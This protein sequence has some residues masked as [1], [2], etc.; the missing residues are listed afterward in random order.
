[1]PT[2]TGSTV[3]SGAGGVTSLAGTGVTVSAS[4]GA[5]TITA[6]VVAGG[7]GI[8]VSGSQT[9]SLSVTNTGVTSLV[10]GSGISVS[11]ATGAVTV[12]ASGYTFIQRIFVATSAATITFSS[13]PSGYTHY[14]MIILGRSDKAG[15]ANDT[16]SVK[17]NNDSAA[18]YRTSASTQYF[19]GAWSVPAATAFPAPHMASAAVIL[20]NAGNSTHYTIADAIRVS[21]V[22]NTVYIGAASPQ[23]YVW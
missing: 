23:P 5:V 9:T 19:A 6:P 14:Y 1:M 15:F 3:P 18:N 2:Y 12:S 16:F 20:Y 8:S 10:A 22:T 7:T 17:F 21:A 11:A 4:T 13:I